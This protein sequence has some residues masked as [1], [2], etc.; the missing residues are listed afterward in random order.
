MS[1][2]KLNEYPPMVA[3]NVT[4]GEV[5]VS[6]SG[7]IYQVTKG[8]GICLVKLGD[9]GFSENNTVEGCTELQ[10]KILNN[11]VGVKLKELAKKLEVTKD[12]IYTKL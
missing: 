1:Y 5:L 4:V 11:I 10:W 3:E 7:N 12:E 9:V 6:S 2:Y 8:S